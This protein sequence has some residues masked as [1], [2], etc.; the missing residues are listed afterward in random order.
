[1]QR[2]LASAAVIATLALAGSAFACPYSESASNDQ[3][4]VTAA[5]PDQTTAP[6]TTAPTTTPKT[7]EASTGG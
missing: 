7:P 6:A 3:T 1:M 2:Y 4:V 5:A